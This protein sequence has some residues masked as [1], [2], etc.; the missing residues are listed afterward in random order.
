MAINTVMLVHT[1]NGSEDTSSVIVPAGTTQLNLFGVQSQDTTAGSGNAGDPN[2]KALVTLWGLLPNAAAYVQLNQSPWTG[3]GNQHGTI[4]SL[5][6]SW[7]FTP[8]DM[9]NVPAGTRI[10]CHIDSLGTTLNTG[11]TIE[12]LP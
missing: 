2:A 7:A 6:F 5:G 1:F 4:P 3:G 12:T 8:Q 10:Y 9:Q 11:F